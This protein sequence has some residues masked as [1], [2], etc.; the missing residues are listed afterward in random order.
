MTQRLYTDLI[1]IISV[2]ACNYPGP[3]G[4]GGAKANFL[5]DLLYQGHY[6]PC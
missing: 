1:F 6:L 5:T 2:N 4:G 3:G